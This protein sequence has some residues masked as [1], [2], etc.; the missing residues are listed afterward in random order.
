MTAG[1]AVTGSSLTALSIEQFLDRLASGDATPGGG[2]AASLA[3]ALGAALVSMVCNLTAGRERFA[4]VEEEVG[5]ILAEAER[6]RAR[7]QAGV[8]ADAA[9]YGGVMAAVGLPRGTELEKEARRE[10]IQVA[11]KGATRV[12]LEIV[13][14]CVAVL[15]LCEQAVRSTNPNAA[16]DVVVAALLAAAGLEGAAANVETNLGSIKDEEFVADARRRLAAVRE[17][18]QQR[19]AVILEAARERT[20]P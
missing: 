14:G 18:L 8:Q 5:A 3:G 13:E 19:V 12:P 1:G 7:L 2:S 16:S 10:A 6:A 9:A 4:D 20:K 11:M 15:T 17:S